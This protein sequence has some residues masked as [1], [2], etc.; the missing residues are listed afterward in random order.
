MESLF[1]LILFLLLILPV[2]AIILAIVAKVGANRAAREAR[3]AG[4]R[5]RLLGAELG[6][7]KKRIS[8]F[9][10]SGSA[11]TKVE[12]SPQTE[13]ASGQVSQP[14]AAGEEERAPATREVPPIPVGEKHPAPLEMMEEKPSPEAVEPEKIVAPEAV[15]VEEGTGAEEVE[16]EAQAP[17]H[18]EEVAS[19][20]DFEEAVEEEEGEEE[21]E[22]ERP[23]TVPGPTIFSTPGYDQPPPLVEEEVEEETETEEVS[24]TTASHSASP[25]KRGWHTPYSPSPE[26]GSIW[27]GLDE[28]QSAHDTP[29]S[30]PVPPPVAPLRASKKAG[31]KS[32][33]K[34]LGIAFPVWIGAIALALSGAFLVKYSVEHGM[35]G[36]TARVAIATLLGLAFLVAGEWLLRKKTPMPAQGACAAGIA[37]LYAAF[38]GAV[39]LYHILNP[40]IGFSLLVLVTAAGVA[41]SL[42]HGVVVAFVGLIGGFFTPYFIGII[43]AS[44]VRLFAYLLLLQGALLIVTRKRRW[45]G[46]TTLTLVLGMGAAFQRMFSHSAVHDA[47][48]IGLF[49]LLS[50]G[51]FIFAGRSWGEKK[52]G[53]EGATGGFTFGNLLGLLT[54]LGALGALLALAIRTGFATEEWVFLGI[55]DLG[56][57]AMARLDA[58]NHLLAWVAFLCTV[59]LQ[60]GWVLR[61]RAAELP[62]VL[63]VVSIMGGIF[64]LASYLAHSR[65]E[66]PS[67]WATLS[68]LWSLSAFGLAYQVWKLHGEYDVHWGYLSL[69]VAIIYLPAVVKAVKPAARAGVEG[70]ETLAAF[71]VAATTFVSLAL[72]LELSNEWIAVG[73]AMEA[74]VLAW[75]LTKIRVKALGVMGLL[76]GTGVVIR[77]LLNPSVL[78]YPMGHLPV[79]NW[80]LYGY[81]IPLAAFAAAALFFS[82]AAWRRTSL[83]FAW[84]AGAFAFALLTLEV[85]QGFHT[86]HLTR[87][88]PTLTEWATYSHIWLGAALLFLL[89]HRRWKANIFNHLAFVFAAIAVVKVVVLDCLAVNPLFT[90]FNVGSWPVVNWIFYVYGPAVLLTALV[91]LLFKGAWNGIPTKLFAWTSGAFAFVLLCLEVRQG[92]HPAHLGNSF[93]G[94]TEWATYSHIW[95]AA[96]FILLFLHRKW[97]AD[98]FSHLAFVFAAI[99]VV[100]IIV[101]DCLAANPLATHF[102]VGSWPVVN[103]LLYAY[104]MHVV[105]AAL[106][107][108]S[109]RGKWQG[110]SSETFAWASAAF[111]LVFLTMEVR[112]WFHPWV[113]YR[114]TPGIVEWAT[115]SNLWLMAGLAL[116]LVFRKRG[117]ALFERLGLAYA[118]IAIV[119]IGLIDLLVF[120][121]IWSGSNVGILPVWNWTLYVY[122]FP[123]VMLA[124]FARLGDRSRFEVRTL[125]AWTS[126]FLLFCL[127]GMEARQW[128]HHGNLSKG[129]TGLVELTTYS[130]VWFI[131]AIAFLVAYRRRG[132][133]LFRNL[134]WAFGAVAFCKMVLIDLLGANPLWNSYNVG[135]HPFFNWLLYAYGLP[136]LLFAVFALLSRD[137]K[138]GVA[139]SRVAMV[140]GYVLALVLLTLEVRQFFHHPLLNRGALLEVE[141]YSYSAVWIL[142]ALFLLVVGIVNKGK[143]TRFASL[144]V[145]F[146][147]V[148]KVFVYDLRQLKDLYRVGSFLALGVSLLLIAF[149]Y[150]RFVFAGDKNE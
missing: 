122:G 29:P 31:D 26:S 93:P 139:F 99:A 66:H 135:D 85:R 13:A 86:A 32:W 27:A 44:P 97:K 81:G 112:Q 126:A 138:L 150:Q 9:E 67:R 11:H 30:P 147:A 34:R 127:L 14:E 25:P 134:A 98:I 103:W 57:I 43:S 58:R 40:W 2:V 36:P 116:Y 88:F 114:G 15:E 4:N 124:C 18:E 37:V 82:R 77:L 60:E 137:D 110:I 120:N 76:V 83:A 121:P 48:W 129:M 19:S 95:F 71:C 136:I 56:I 100:K 108:L 8:L 39:V 61:S 33:E 63:L 65:D 24:Q 73:W 89:F 101:V 79:L 47:R 16:V 102:N 131:A 130:H 105:L 119:K 140:G 148:S 5:A 1:L 111:G 53:E 46:L 133:I 84:T 90:G 28:K 96:A 145:I 87:G 144:V 113:L 22:D 117:T 91:A 41:L 51:A 3:E 146:L 141:N 64:A 104:G 10:A 72:P 45:T 128:F 132:V 75:L 55:L 12:E 23:T 54:I 94:L 21:L 35:I 80:F 78:Y 106:V 68:I 69:L 17:T 109:C 50:A 70:E 92:F 62:R 125:S 123:M 118:A 143:G 149:L 52:F 142:F 74:A 59:L 20:F 7:L 6:A 115:Y 49:L 38:L 107:A 42:R